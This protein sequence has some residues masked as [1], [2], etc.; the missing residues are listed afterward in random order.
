MSPE[1][2]ER[3]TAQKLCLE[4]QLQL[5]REYERLKDAIELQKQILR[6][7]ALVLSVVKRS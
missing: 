3:I 6:Q 5:I 2:Q 4:R 7:C 1:L